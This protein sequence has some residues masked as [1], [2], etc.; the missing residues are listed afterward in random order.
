[1]SVELQA[2]I[3][4][5][6]HI[7]PF[8]ICGIICYEY[9][10]YATMSQ[11]IAK[12]EEHIMRVWYENSNMR[13]EQLREMYNEMREALIHYHNINP[14]IMVQKYRLEKLEMEEKNRKKEQSE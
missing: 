13:T 8:I 6:L 11:K 1:M 10:A 5:I 12:D 7:V 3:N 2:A 14:D 4:I 9:V